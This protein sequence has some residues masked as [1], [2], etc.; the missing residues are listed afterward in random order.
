MVYLRGQPV[1]ILASE[2]GGMRGQ[3]G[4]MAD[5]GW[6]DVRRGEGKGSEDR[7]VRGEWRLF[8]KL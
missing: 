7:L 6:P 5:D 1:D 8:A 3:P 2:V 4:H